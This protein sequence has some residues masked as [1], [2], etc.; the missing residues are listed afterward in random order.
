MKVQNIPLR[1]ELAKELREIF[2]PQPILVG[3]DYSELELRIV[4]SKKEE[5]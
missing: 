5:S 3:L 4:L 1:T 2:R